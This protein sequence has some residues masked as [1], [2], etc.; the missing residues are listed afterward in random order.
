MNNQDN[1]RQWPNLIKINED[2]KTLGIKL[3]QTIDEN[4]IMSLRHRLNSLISQRFD[5]TQF[6]KE[7]FYF[8]KGVAS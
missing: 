3:S 8:Q 1:Y 7:Q 4:E 6:N 2:I 5:Q